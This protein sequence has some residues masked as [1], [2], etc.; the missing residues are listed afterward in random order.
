M[1]I[2]IN[3]TCLNKYTS[4]LP[5]YNLYANEPV[6]LYTTSNDAR[7]SRITNAHMTLSPFVRWLKFLIWCCMFNA[8]VIFTHPFWGFSLIVIFLCPSREGM[9]SMMFDYAA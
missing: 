6:A 4:V 7:T 5:R 8:S 2:V 1:P 9:N 3:A